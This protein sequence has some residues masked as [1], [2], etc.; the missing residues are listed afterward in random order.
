M[1]LNPGY[2]LKSFLLYL[3]SIIII[4]Q[5]WDRE[6]SWTVNSSATLKNHLKNFDSKVHISKHIFPNLKILTWALQFATTTTMWCD[7]LHCTAVTH[8]N[9]VRIWKKNFPFGHYATVGRIVELKSAFFFHSLM[10]AWLS[11]YVLK[12]RFD[13][14]LESM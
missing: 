11:T 5:E 9:F 13:F 6:I 7:T 2:F 4:C 12:T 1:G 10:N 14:Y 8:L 3:Y